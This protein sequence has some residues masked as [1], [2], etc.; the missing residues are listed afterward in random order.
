MNMGKAAL[1]GVT[2]LVAF[3][4]TSVVNPGVAS[5]TTTCSGPTFTSTISNTTISGNV[6]VPNGAWCYL[7]NVTVGG[8]VT[9]EPGSD[10]L[11]Q[12]SVVGG[13]VTGRSASISVF[14]PGTSI[15]GGSVTAASGQATNLPGSLFLCG[16]TVHG[17]VTV[18]NIPTLTKGQY[19]I[20]GSSSQRVSC[21]GFGDGN[22][23]GGGVTVSSNNAPGDIRSNTIGGNL[24]CLGN[25]P[26][27]TGGS[28][29]V[30]GS[31]IGQCV[32]L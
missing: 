29:T 3:V 20:G 1:A 12:N 6:V 17:T 11:V 23:V 15:V 14:G 5:A 16:T 4:L 26:P 30:S 32:G 25:T 13:S 9:A 7:L 19:A 24:T 10:L 2:G 31:K 18:A 27:P 21:G 8:S 28:N 22:H